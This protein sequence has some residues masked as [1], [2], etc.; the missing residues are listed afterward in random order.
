MQVTILANGHVDCLFAD[1]ELRDVDLFAHR[2]NDPKIQYGV[3]SQRVDES[4]EDVDVND[5]GLMSFENQDR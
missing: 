4:Q 3:R 1:E 5:V 2:R